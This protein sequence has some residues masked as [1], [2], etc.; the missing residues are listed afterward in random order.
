MR[1]L[2]LARLLS[3]GEDRAE[4]VLGGVATVQG[5]SLVRVL[6]R[7]S[8]LSGV[9][10]V[11]APPFTLKDISEVQPLSEN[12]V[13]GAVVGRSCRRQGWGE[14]MGEAAVFRWCSRTL[15]QSRQ[16][17]GSFGSRHP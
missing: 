9:D 16:Q 8:A 13:S 14:Y 7:Y 17:G 4:L 3:A 1:V 10:L 6:G 5:H 11:Q 15:W 2:G 12:P